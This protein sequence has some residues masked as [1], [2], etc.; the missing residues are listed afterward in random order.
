MCLCL[1]NPLWQGTV[2]SLGF[3][4]RPNHRSINAM[5][6]SSTLE[7]WNFTV[8]DPIVVHNP[9][10]TVPLRNDPLRVAQHVVDREK[11]GLVEQP[12]ASMEELLGLAKDW[13]RD[14]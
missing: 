11:G 1:R 8:I 2:W 3:S 6:A 10:A 13:V 14:D 4:D 9:Y 5:M 7:A 12:G